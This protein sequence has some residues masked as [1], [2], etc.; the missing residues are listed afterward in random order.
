MSKPKAVLI[1]DVHFNINTLALASEA[2][3][4]ALIK[5]KELSVPLIIAG[6]LLDQKAL[7]RAECANSIISLLKEYASVPTIILVGNHD[8]LNERSKEHSLHFLKPYS[9]L[10]DSPTFNKNLDLWLIPYQPS[11]D[12]LRSLLNTIPSNST[13]IMHQGLM[14]ADMGH[15][16]RDNTAVTKDDVSNFRVISGHYHKRQDIKSGRPKSGA[17]G[18]F[19]YIGNPY[20]LNFAESKDPEKGFQILHDNGLLSHCSINVR[21]HVKLVVNIKD[22]KFL[23]EKINEDDLLWVVLEGD[24]ESLSTVDK[25]ELGIILFNRADYKLDFSPIKST[26]PG[27][28]ERTFDKTKID[29][30]FD[31]LIDSYTADEEY[32]ILLKFDW[33]D[34]I[35]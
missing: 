12:E 17:V 3:K 29:E 34:L 14:D 28:H 10:I 16:V 9:T 22:I 18:L 4:S 33:K 2:L 26:T 23:G 6:D 31:S 5:A 21:K 13:I 32:R 8:L 27:E 25:K 1:S 19:S 35:Q 24:Q 7:I 30:I 15:Y 20:T 11:V